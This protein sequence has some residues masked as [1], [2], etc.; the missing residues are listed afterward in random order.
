MTRTIADG[1]AQP[2]ALAAFDGVV[3]LAGETGLTR[4]DPDGYTQVLESRGLTSLA[5]GCD[6]V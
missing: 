3:Y 5:I 1:F 2:K 6:A 4:T